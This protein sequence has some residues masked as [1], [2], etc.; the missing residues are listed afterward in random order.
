MKIK[1]SIFLLSLF[2][3]TACFSNASIPEA[4]TVETEA[5]VN[6]SPTQSTEKVSQEVVTVSQTEPTEATQA[7]SPTP[8]EVSPMSNPTQ[9]TGAIEQNIPGNTL[10]AFSGDEP[11]WYTVDDDV[12]GG[13][14][15]SMVGV[16][17]TGQLLFA[18]TMSLENNGGFASV[19]S[20]W[21]RM[22]LSSYDGVLMRVLGDGNSYRLRIRTEETGRNISYN[23]LFE[24]TPET[25][26]LVY[27]PFE[28]MVPTYFGRTLALDPVDRASIGSFGIMLSDKQP[29]E[30]AL[31]VDWMRTVTED[32]L[33]AFIETQASE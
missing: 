23:A 10:F 14:S 30:F 33:R 1:A 15:S 4:T 12:M 32:E 26:K 13:V 6:V 11:G 9:S 25:W 3:L 21:Q 22:D 2:T 18:G 24:T 7:L 17:E 31:A 29:G 5:V 8:T 27:I 28:D 19:R 20:Y 16:S